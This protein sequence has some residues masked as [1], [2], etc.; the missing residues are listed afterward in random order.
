MS[1]A[2]GISH[3]ACSAVPRPRSRPLVLLRHAAVE[4]EPAQPP[5]LW[6]LSDDGRRATRRLARAPLWRAV[7][8][9][10]T[11]PAI[12]AQET[13][14]IIAGANGITVTVI[15][16]LREVERPVGQWF[17]D[18]YPGGYAAAVAAWFAAPA[19]ATHGWEP[20]AAAQTR[21]TACIDDL[22]G[23]EE[24]PVAVCGHGLTLSLYLNALTGAAPSAL[25][26]TIGFPDVA[27]VDPVRRR[28]LHPF[29]RS[30]AV[31]G[32]LRMPSLR[33]GCAD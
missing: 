18:T 4:A 16:D 23:W 19:V 33:R 27:V 22:L 15:A 28:V 20:P 24:E 5:S 8:R 12:K 21:I 25:W 17:D 13:A 26:P 1:D 31:A 6:P 10:F 2:A 11:S 29:G 30:A 3:A 14:Q 32:A 9:I 7:V